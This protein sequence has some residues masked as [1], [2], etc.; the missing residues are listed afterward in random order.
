[1]NRTTATANAKEKFLKKSQSIN[2]NIF[3]TEILKPLFSCILKCRVDFNGGQNEKGKDLIAFKVDE[4][5][6]KDPIG[7]Q[8]KKIKFSANS[9]GKNI[10]QLLVQIE[11]IKHEKIIDIDT[12]DELSISKIYIVTPY[13]ISERVAESSNGAIK[14][15]TKKGVKILDGEKIYSL[16][17]EHNPHLL[18]NFIGESTEVWGKIFEAVNRHNQ[19]IWNS[20]NYKNKKE[21]SNIYCNIG[22]NISHKNILKFI[23][24][25]L[26]PKREIKK[27]LSLESKQKEIDFINLY[28]EKITG[29]TYYNIE[30]TN[31]LKSAQKEQKIDL[32]SNKEEL[33]LLESE[34]EILLNSES[35]REF[36][37]KSNDSIT[38]FLSQLDQNSNED[39]KSKKLYK[40]AGNKIIKLRISINSIKSRVGKIE[41]MISD[42]E[43]EVEV[44]SSHLIEALNLVKNKIVNSLTISMP[45]RLELIKKCSGII[46]FIDSITKHD[47]DLRPYN[48]DNPTEKSEDELS[49]KTLEIL[50][51]KINSEIIDVFDTG[52][53]ILVSGEAGSGKTTNLQ[54]YTLNLHKRDTKKFIFYSTLNEIFKNISNPSEISISLAIYNSIFENETLLSFSDFKS[55]LKEKN[56]VI[57][58][59]SIDECISKYPDVIQYLKK[60]KEDYPLAQVI[61]SARHTVDDTL[62][63]GF[64]CISLLPFTKAQKKQFFSKW[65]NDE[66]RVQTILDHLQNNPD[67]DKI[68]TNPLSSTI[69]AVLHENN[70]AL[71]TTE[72]ALYQRRFDLLSGKLDQYKQ[73]SRTI[74][75][76]EDILKASYILAFN[77][78]SLKKRNFTK[79]LAFNI[80]KGES[81]SLPNYE[82]IFSEMIS[83]CEILHV[84]EDESYDFGHLKF[85][86]YLAA[87]EIEVNH[88]IN[89]GK[90]LKSKAWWTEFL[91]LYAQQ[92]R[93]VSWIIDY[94]CRGGIA[95]KNK[96]VS[97]RILESYNGKNKA[98]LISRLETSISQE[99]I[100]KYGVCKKNCVSGILSNS[101]EGIKNAN[102]RPITGSAVS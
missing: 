65:F 94:I 77:I 62:S 79:Q 8:V 46:N 25:K 73:V 97:L 55:N 91:S 90:L 34:L 69:L 66:T 10:A 47:V 82:S 75:S 63:L 99:T 7:I 72:S 87:K 68:V 26:I 3:T 100:D 76:P 81:I 14:E 23:K 70:V 50:S 59:D 17:K 37:D 15:L 45:E 80:L 13:E 2:E 54:A 32:K 22:F 19:A 30:K 35:G 49:N 18:S 44:D 6:C 71:P 40:T 43:V 93:D 52:V 27:F 57:V 92:S 11:Q 96:D 5:G 56:S 58:L 67:L 16:L 83:P 29:H 36:K 60:F 39:D 98:E 78:H 74:N 95:V 21:I 4:F 101:L 24:S 42:N 61:T 84:N 48:I 33:F 86:E 38:N 28:A 53:D 85:Q 64:A 31:G 9:Q 102:Y 41:Q 20:L 12:N 51:T 1:M 88:S 89:L